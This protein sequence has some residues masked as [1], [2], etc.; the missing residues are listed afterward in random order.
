[1]LIEE[2]RKRRDSLKIIIDAAKFNE[3]EER[4][5]RCSINGGN[6]TYDY[7]C[8]TRDNSRGLYI[9]KEKIKLAREMA[10]N[11]YNKKIYKAAQKELSIIEKALEVETENLTARLYENCSP[12]RK[13]LITP[14]DVTDEEYARIWESRE[15]K[16]KGFAPDA[17]ELYS[18]KG[19]RVRSKSELI[20][21]DALYDL[22]IPYLYECPLLLEGFG[23][24]YPD[25]TM[26]HKKSRMVKYLEHLGMMGDPD[27]MNKALKKIDMYG[28]NGIFLGYNLLTTYETKDNPP[29]MRIIR[30]MLAKTML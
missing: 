19:D 4:Y 3:N 5:L 24:V 26:L 9:P 25:F 13:K 15:Y 11:T 14:L 8:C 16:R 6:D 10:Q 12:G 2:L 27:Y 18:K 21:A 17:Q 30:R 22:G 20:I 28:K 1:M 23:I 7:Y 29:D